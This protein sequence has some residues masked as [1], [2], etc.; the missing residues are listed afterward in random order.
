MPLMDS[1]KSGIRELRDA[2]IHH[3]GIERRHTRV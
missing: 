2:H 1:T 3:H